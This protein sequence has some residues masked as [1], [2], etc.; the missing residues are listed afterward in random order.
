MTRQ[1]SSRWKRPLFRTRSLALCALCAAAVLMASC[2]NDVIQQE[3]QRVPVRAATARID[4]GTRGAWTRAFSDPL[5]FAP[6]RATDD[7]YTSQFDGGETIQLYLDNAGSATNSTYTVSNSDHSTLTGGNLYYPSGNTGSVTL[8]GVYPSGS[9][10]SHTVLYDQTID[11]NYKASDLMY[12]RTV[13]DLANKAST[14]SLSFGHQLIKLKLNIV[15]DAAVSQVTQVMMKNVKRTV[16]V[17]VTSSALTPGTAAATTSSDNA[18][19]S[20]GD[21]ILISSGESASASQETY[22]YAVVFPAQSWTAQDFIE[23]SADGSTATYQLTRSSWTAGSEYELT[24]NL[25][26]LNLGSTVSIDDWT[27]GGTCT[28]NPVSSSGGELVINPISDQRYTGSD[29]QPTLTVSYNSAAVSGYD[30]TWYNN[31]QIGTAMVV[32]VGNS[33]AAQNKVGFRTFNIISGDGSISYAATTVNKTYG[34][35]AFTNVLTHTGDGTV[36]YSSSD[37]TVA[38]VNSSSGQVTILKAGSTTITAT[39]A[40]GA[41]YTYATKTA[42]YTLTVAKKAATITFSTTTPSKTWSATTSNNTY[43]Q[44]VSNTG[45]ATPTY[46]IG[47]TN[48]CGATISGSTISFTKGGSVTVNATVADTDKYTYATKTVSYTLT[49]NKAAGSVTLSATSGSVTAGS[50]TS[51]T[52]T[53]NTSG[54]TLSI[55][56]N[57]NT[58]R[59]TAT[60]SGTTVNITTN[61]T[62]AASATITVQ[63]AETDTYNAATATYTLT[64]NSQYT[65]ASSATA[66][67]V[68]KIICSNGHIHATVSAVESGASAVAM[69]VYVGSAGTADASSSTY[70]GLAI[71]LTDASISAAWYGTSSAYTSTCVYQNS[72]FSNHYG[73]A[74]M[75]GITNTNQMA[76]KTGNCSSH[77]THAAATAAKNYS[78]TVSV[79]S[80]CS[81]WFLPTSGQWFRFFRNGTLNLSWSDWGYNSTGSAGYTAVNKMFTDAGATDAVFSSG[82]LYWSSSEYS[83]SYAVTVRFGS[84]DGVYVSGHLKCNT[85]RVRAFLAF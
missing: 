2:I 70:K 75:K 44:T 6:T 38:T 17:T 71:A 50:S 16:P 37:A 62:T 45:D 54:G 1:H 15:K 25:G 33:G 49:V 34:D 40:D 77:T 53:G 8:Y 72:T 73:Y 80:G 56:N 81:Q 46:S 9:T 18:D 23:I 79:P 11:A 59:C 21:N 12:A 48:T 24:L 7:L 36:T 27:G 3:E 29:I 4:G 47:S 14:Q 13:V 63:S 82:A 35:A 20:Y 84:S 64:I 41:N 43:S 67:D 76:N 32:V 65:N 57:S 74:D 85:R 69:I 60:L 55:S 5:S 66:D 42:S 52:V 83:S 51:F 31:T 58:S 68:G 19:Y 78:N 26:L 22:T 28:V 61:G 10:S 39:V 30:A